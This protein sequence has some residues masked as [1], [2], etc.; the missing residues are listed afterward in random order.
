MGSLD[1]LMEI[2]DIFQKCDQQ[3]DASCKRNEK[4]Y[5]DICKELN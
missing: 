5:Y 4:M 3:I 1:Q 2:M